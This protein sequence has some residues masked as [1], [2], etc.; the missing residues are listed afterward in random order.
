MIIKFKLFE[1]NSPDI[2]Q[3]EYYRRCLE[4]AI[5]S[6]S[7]SERYGAILVKDGKILGEG[8]NRAISHTYFKLDRILKQGYANHAEVEAMNNALEK[9]YDITDSDIYV[10]GYFPKTGILF[11]K[12]EFTC[13]LCLPY[14]KKFQIRNIFVPLPSGWK[15]R[16]EEECEKDSLLFNRGTMHSDRLKYLIGNYNISLLK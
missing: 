5:K 12:E 10:A 11:F 8:Y 14:F 6:K 2:I 15:K 13:K 9:E 16:T 1:S 3:D 4:N 7:D